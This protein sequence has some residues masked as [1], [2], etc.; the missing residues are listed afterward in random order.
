METYLEGESEVSERLPPAHIYIPSSGK[1][2]TRE[3]MLEQLLRAAG[4]DP[5]KGRKNLVVLTLLEEVERGMYTEYEFRRACAR[6]VTVT[7]GLR[8]Y[9]PGTGNT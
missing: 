8:N 6:L 7:P 1:T 2:R 5:E 3:E 4:I 9:G